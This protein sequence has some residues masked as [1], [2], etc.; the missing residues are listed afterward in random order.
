MANRP[1]RRHLCTTGAEGIHPSLYAFQASKSSVKDTGMWSEPECFQDH[2]W[3]L[4]ARTRG[5]QER[6]T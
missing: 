2:S 4:R 5:S 3:T 6:V 1:P